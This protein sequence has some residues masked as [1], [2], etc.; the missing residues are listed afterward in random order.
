MTDNTVTI[1]LTNGF[2]TEVRRLG[3]FEIQDFVG[4][5]NLAPYT[6]EGELPSGQKYRQFYDLSYDRPKPDT[7][8]ELC[9]KNTGDYWD[10]VEW[11][12]W[13][14]G[15]VYE[16]QRIN[17]YADYCRNAA[18]YIRRNAIVGPL[19]DDITVEDWHAITQAALCHTVT[20]ADVD[21]AIVMLEANY[22]GTPLS[23]AYTNVAK[24]GL[25]YDFRVVELDLMMALRETEDIYFSRSVMD[26]A[27]LIAK[28]QI[29][30][31]GQALD[32]RAAI[33]QT[34]ANADG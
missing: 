32:H 21:K 16:Q 3:L 25:S 31:M 10:W 34:K 8:M 6:I 15:L 9:E 22:Q 19:P 28:D 18:D 20:P 17:A 26:R 5:P 12:N 23:E 27:R 4:Q 1:E 7:P 13:Q 30:A 24:S 14:D 29:K 2:K 33:E 11:H